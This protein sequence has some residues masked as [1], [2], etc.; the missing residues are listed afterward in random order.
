MTRRT[1]YRYISDGRLAKVTHSGRVYVTRACLNAY[2]ANL[3]ADG[4]RTQAAT[5]RRTTRSRRT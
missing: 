5:R 1:F 3:A 2:W 4:Q